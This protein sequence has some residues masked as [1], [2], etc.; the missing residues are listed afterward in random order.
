M[1]ARLS[2]TTR[3]RRST[4][5][6][7]DRASRVSLSYLANLINHH[8]THVASLSPAHT[9]TA[10]IQLKLDLN[11]WTTAQNN[12]LMKQDIIEVYLKDYRRQMA[13]YEAEITRRGYSIKGGALV[14]GAVVPVVA[15]SLAPAKSTTSLASA[16]SRSAGMA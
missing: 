7:M 9:P 15:S 2:L 5:H 16:S 11:E 12:A 3:S 4:S 6:Y 13:S 10:Q 14:A 1:H 8:F